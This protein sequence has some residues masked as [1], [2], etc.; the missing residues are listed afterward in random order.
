[1]RFALLSHVLPPSPSGQAVMLFRILSRLDPEIFYLIS[2][3]SEQETFQNTNKQLPLQAPSFSLPPEPLLKGSRHFGLDP[4]RNALNILIRIIVRTL[5]MLKIV[6]REPTNAIIACSGDLTNI[7]AG[8]LISRIIHVPFFAY[9]FD[10]Y[11]YQWRGNYRR[12]AK[13]IGQFIFKHSAGIIGPNE[14]ICQEYRQRYNIT[15][16][17]VRNPCENGFFKPFL[18]WPAESDKIK[19]IYTGAIYHANYDCFWNLIR[20]M[21]LLEDYHLEL[22]IYTAQ[23]YEELEEQQ[24]K[25]KKVIVHSHVPYKD[26]LEHQRKGDILFLPLAF[27]SPIPEVIRTSAPGKMGE[28][29]A[30]GRPILAHVPPNS[31]VAD[32]FKRYQCGS[33]VDQKEP[34]KLAEGIKNLI[35]DLTLRNKI[36]KNAQRQAQLDFSAEL[37]SSSLMALLRQFSTII[38][39]P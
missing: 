6:H 8:F 14:Y 29:L 22:H 23:T 26:I 10:D 12:F 36:I 34:R 9:I 35:V 19:I 16:T 39:L 38:A 17:L 25:G 33:I 21:D 31:F 32:Y 27:E 37:A 4:I 20:A 7:P 2:S 24:I 15:P 13:F 5:S 3:A 18:K 30:S 1:M 11:V 28:Y